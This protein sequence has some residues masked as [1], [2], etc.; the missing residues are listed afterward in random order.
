MKKLIMLLMLI[1]LVATGCGD[2][3]VV[4][5]QPFT[6]KTATQHQYIKSYD[7]GKQQTAY[8]GEPIIKWQHI[9]L[10]K[11]VIGE[12]YTTSSDFTLKGKYLKRDTFS[13]NID[14]K[15]TIRDEYVRLGTTNYNN[16]EY[17]VLGKTIN[18]K[19]EHF[20]LLTDKNGVL[21]KNILID[22]NQDRKLLPVDVPSL[23]PEKVVFSKADIEKDKTSDGTT[24]EIIFGG[25]NNVTLNATYREY[26]PD[27]LARQAFFQS[28]VYQTSADTI[29]F[30]GFK[31]KVHEVTNEKITFTVLEDDLKNTN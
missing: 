19:D 23:S 25:V 3:R 8:I 12:K 27:N 17:I 20:Y 21:D 29:R 13:Y 16:T 4:P 14:I 15:S 5:D 24:H 22:E 9:Y 10:T 2:I 28:L 30:R 11:N 7:I 1:N 6:P 18:G 31:I 26:S